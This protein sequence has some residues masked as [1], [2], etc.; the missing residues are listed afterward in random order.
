MV[1]TTKLSIQGYSIYKKELTE[2]DIKR[3]KNEL[4]VEP[5][6]YMKS[7]YNDT[8]DSFCLLKENED[9]E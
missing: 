7:E 5:F 3:I 8:D 1:L 9:T 2:S 4:T 6:N